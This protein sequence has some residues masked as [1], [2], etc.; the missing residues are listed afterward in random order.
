M[1]DLNMKAT[2]MIVQSTN[3]DSSGK[4]GGAPTVLFTGKKYLLLQDPATKMLPYKHQVAPWT[5]AYAQFQ[6]LCLNKWP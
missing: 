5:S 4:A 6:P 3:A 2:P 1:S